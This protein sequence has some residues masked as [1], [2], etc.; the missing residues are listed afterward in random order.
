MTIATQ[1]DAGIAALGL[2]LEAEVRSRLVDFLAI[3]QKWNRVHNLTAVRDPEQ[4]VT[5]HLLDC[6]A[7]LDNVRGPRILDVGSGGGFPGIPLALAHPDWDLTLLDSN[8]KKCAFLRQATIEL[9][10][11][12]VNVI[13]ERVEKYR[14]EPG[15]DTVI[16]RAFSDIPEY[17]SV[18]GH[19]VAQDGVILAMKGVY[20]NEELAQ[21]PAGFALREVVELAI[22][23]LDARRHLVVLARTGL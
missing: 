14:V 6:L 13:S 15:F 17:L 4:M 10:L 20:P 19:L 1:L 22:P 9:G 7:V 23:G 16:S 5:H 8:H 11:K 21:L 2:S 18:A 12:N 3:L